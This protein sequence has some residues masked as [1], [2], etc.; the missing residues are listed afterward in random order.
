MAEKIYTLHSCTLLH[1]RFV[2]M[3][4]MLNFVISINLNKTVSINSITNLFNIYF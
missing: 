1:N 2:F 3:H 4:V